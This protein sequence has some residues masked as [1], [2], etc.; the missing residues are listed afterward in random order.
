MKTS[1]SRLAYIAAWRKANPE[2]V[3]RAANK[4]AQKAYWG[5]PDNARKKARDWRA[6]NPTAAREIRLR[7]WAK[8]SAK[9][10]REIKARW[11]KRNRARFPEK[12]RGRKV[13]Q[14]HNLS[15]GYVRSVISNRSMI[16]SA[17]WPQEYVETWRSFLQ[18]KRICKTQKTSKNS[19][20]SC[21]KKSPTSE[22]THAEPTKPKKLSTALVK[23]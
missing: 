21:S 12:W 22:K 23:S 5:D 18:L 1:A 9:Q 4:Y 7:A 20:L 13:R 19:E 15:D 6:R 11:R 2:S 14:I 16:S 8:L 3:K 17:V 10:K